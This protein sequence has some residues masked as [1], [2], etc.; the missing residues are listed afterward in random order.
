MLKVGQ[1]EY[2][3]IAHRV[4][5]KGIRQIARE[6]GHSRNTVRKALR[7]QYSGYS[8]RTKQ[9]YPVLGPYVKIIDKWLDE[10]KIR[11]RKQR[12]TARRIYARL[13]HEHACLT[14]DR[15]LRAVR[16]L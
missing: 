2:I 13:C 16:G 14:A 9:P 8:G 4:Y 5:G 6:T 1:Y 10:D 15:V 3:R 7:E 11:P 12:H